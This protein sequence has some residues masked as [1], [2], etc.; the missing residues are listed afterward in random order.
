M[1]MDVWERIKNILGF[2]TYTLK[3][4]LLYPSPS[5]IG[6]KDFDYEVTHFDA[7]GACLSPKFA[8]DKYY[9]IW[10]DSDIETLLEALKI[11]EN[12]D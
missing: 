6:L 8:N 10:E 2:G 7:K 11:I 12:H 3:T 1:R 9:H 5:G 4:P